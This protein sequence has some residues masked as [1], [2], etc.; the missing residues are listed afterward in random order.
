MKDIFEA[1][2][3]EDGTIKKSAQDYNIRQG[4]TTKPIVEHQAPSVQVLHAVLRCFDHFMK[5]VVHM[6]AGV[7]IW[8]ETKLSRSTPFLEAEKKKV[9]EAI[10]KETGIK[11]DFVDSSG[12]GGTTTTGN[13]ARA[14]LFE[15]QKR[16]IITNLIRNQSD[17]EITEQFG[18]LLS[19]IL[20]D[21]SS[22]K[23][24][25]I[26]QYKN[27]CK[28]LNLLLL[29][30]IPWASVTPTL[31]KVLAHSWELIE[32]NHQKGLKGLSEEGF[33]ANNK[34]L[35]M[36]REKLSRKN[37]Q[38]SNLEDCFKRL[39][40]GSDPLV[41]QQRANGRLKCSVCQA[42]GHTKRSC[43]SNSNSNNSLLT[44]LFIE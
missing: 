17:R 33:E 13:V 28:D 11:W 18:Y 12:Q 24:I 32:M 10:L 41:C 40:A 36:Y 31:H 6:S 2:V 23:T 34:R 42:I 5:V 14:L 9:Q 15:K 7:H 30:E 3:Q 26:D 4:Q 29:H 44:N 16:D 27:I 37:N 20:R 1:L 39:W 43:P 8:T 25:R 22:D 35:R 21:I 19:T 38:I